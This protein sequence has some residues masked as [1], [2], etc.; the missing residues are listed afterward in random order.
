[1]LIITLLIKKQSP[2]SPKN[3]PYGKLKCISQSSGQKQIR[4][5]KEKKFNEELDTYKV[6]RRAKGIS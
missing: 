2:K 3:D 5:F 1:M 4:C 6:T